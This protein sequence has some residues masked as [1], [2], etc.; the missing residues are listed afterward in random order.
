MGIHTFYTWQNH[1]FGS[2]PLKKKK[3]A[4]Q[5]PQGTRS[6]LRA[7]CGQLYRGIER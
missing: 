6:Y 3:N 2:H 4:C 5:E 7:L 1:K